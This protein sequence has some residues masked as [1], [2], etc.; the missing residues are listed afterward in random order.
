MDS[1]IMVNNSM[2]QNSTFV[3]WLYVFNLIISTNKLTLVQVRGIAVTCLAQS[4]IISQTW[5]WLH[6]T[7]NTSLT[8]NIHAELNVYSSAVIIKS[9][10]NHFTKY[11]WPP[12][13]WSTTQWN[14]IVLSILVSYIFFLL[15][16]WPRRS[17]SLLINW[18][19]SSIPEHRLWI[20][21]DSGPI[22]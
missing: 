16:V 22:V 11:V 14:E 9:Q 21:L 20:P 4:P 7:K 1:F 15:L 12:L 3:A 19:C 5:Y 10:N 17:Q 13:L 18:W 8:D 6:C 2:K